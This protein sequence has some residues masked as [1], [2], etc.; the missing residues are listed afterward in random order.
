[1]VGGDAVDG[2]EGAARSA[3]QCST[4]NGQAAAGDQPAPISI[5]VH[6]VDRVVPGVG[7]GLPGLLDHRIHREELPGPWIVVTPY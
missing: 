4:A 3:I 1:M 5:R 2:R 7:V 6:P